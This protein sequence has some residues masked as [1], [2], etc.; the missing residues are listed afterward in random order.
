MKIE[1]EV[2]R[3]SPLNIADAIIGREYERSY[4]TDANFVNYANESI[5]EIGKALVNHAEAC[6]RLR[7]IEKEKQMDAVKYIE[8]K[9]RMCKSL[10]NCEGCPIRYTCD[11]NVDEA[12]KTVATVEKWSREH[13]G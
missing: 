3:D 13:P 4:S 12:K 6:D 10:P 8:E 9:E 2:M 5:R 1:L 11:P 7:E